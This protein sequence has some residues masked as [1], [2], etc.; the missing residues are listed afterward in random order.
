MIIATFQFSA[1]LTTGVT[2]V[3]GVEAKIQIALPD[4]SE[5]VEPVMVLGSATFSTELKSA[6]FERQ[7]GSH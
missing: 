7:G 6:L 3:T 5:D 4:A 1:I 2:G